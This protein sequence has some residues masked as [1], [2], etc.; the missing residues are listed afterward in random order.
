MRLA[1]F[2]KHAVSAMLMPIASELTIITNS[3]HAHAGQSVVVLCTHYCAQLC[4][5]GLPVYSLDTIG[6]TPRW[7]KLESTHKCRHTGIKTLYQL[8]TTVLIPDTV[9]I[10]LPIWAELAI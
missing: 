9:S 1:T 7:N 2:S 10:M 3:S 4:H 5:E 6:T 8:P